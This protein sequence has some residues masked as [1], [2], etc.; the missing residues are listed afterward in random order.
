[1]SNAG[2]KK[3]TAFVSEKAFEEVV[4]AAKVKGVPLSDLVEFAVV[5]VATR[6]NDRVKAEVAQEATAVAVGAPPVTPATVAAEV[7]AA[8]PKPLPVI[9]ETASHTC[10]HYS[11]DMPY[12][13]QRGHSTIG[14]CN[15]QG[16]KPCQ[17]APQNARQCGLFSPTAVVV[18]GAAR[19]WFR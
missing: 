16:G 15:T 8:A 10:R 5:Q 12:R 19:S 18:P 4:A 9:Q 17:Y 13:F 3:L 6:I 7:A 2:K 1:M 14:T 11:H